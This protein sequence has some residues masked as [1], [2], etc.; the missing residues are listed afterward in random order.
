MIDA[1]DPMESMPFVHVVNTSDQRQTRWLTVPQDIAQAEDLPTEV[2]LGPW[3]AVKGRTVGLHTQLWYCRADVDSYGQALIN[4]WTPLR[5]GYAVPKFHMSEW[6]Q[7]TLTPRPITVHCGSSTMRYQWHL[8]EDHR[9]AKTFRID[10]SQDGWHVKLW[11]TLWSGQD[12]IDL[13][14]YVVWSDP[15]RPEWFLEDQS[16]TISSDFELA[17]YWSD[18]NGHQQLSPQSVKLYHGRVP[19]GVAFPFRGVL[20]PVVADH[21][22][23]GHTEFRR[24]L[25]AASKA[26]P[27]VASTSWPDGQ[28]LAWG[29]S[30]GTESVARREDVLGRLATP[31]HI[32]DQRRYANAANTGATGSQ[33]CFGA[34]KGLQALIPDAWTLWEMMHSA[35]D[36]LLRGRHHRE[37]DG[38][39]VTKRSRP[40]FQTWSGAPERNAPDNLGKERNAPWGWERFGARNV[41]VDDQHRGDAYILAVYALTGDWALLDDIRDSLAVDECRAKTARG[42]LDSPRASGRLWQSWAK[43]ARLLEG[44]DLARVHSLAVDELAMREAEQPLGSP[45]SPSWI[46]NDARVLPGSPA[47]VPWQEALMV[48]GAAE[49]AEVWRRLGDD[50][51]SRRFQAYADRITTTIMTYGVVL[52]QPTQKWLP[53]TGVRWLDGGAELPASYYTHPR[54]GASYAPGSGVDMLVGTEGWWSWFS[55]AVSVGKQSQSPMVRTLAMDIWQRYGAHATSLEQAEWWS[56]R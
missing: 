9:V 32:A 53:L 27:L 34:T 38:S 17:L 5:D 13:R 56:V 29:R 8:V 10:A 3:L 47:W 43:M 51:T 50:A 15:T 22:A 4:H 23:W 33:P 24:D 28:W 37:A 41:L 54:A 1:Q 40:Q 7:A 46:V 14:G 21:D 2:M 35:D 36:Y 18:K 44:I 20:L 55:G 6:I 30:T 39:T 26:G 12:V 45:V 31:G 11:A 42:Q 16:I 19:H 48:L 49:Q 25:M 52:D